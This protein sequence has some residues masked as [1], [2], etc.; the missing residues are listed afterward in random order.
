MNDKRKRG[1]SHPKARHSD[2]VVELVRQVHEAGM[3]PKAI[4]EKFNL[5]I[6]QIN[7]WIYYR[8][9]VSA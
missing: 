5:S 8:T 2:Q 9:R 7:D 1:E 3:M 4:S 6:H